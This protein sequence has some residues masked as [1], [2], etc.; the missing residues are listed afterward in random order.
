MVVDERA[1]SAVHRTIGR[2]ARRARRHVR[3]VF[4][5]FFRI[6]RMPIRERSTIRCLAMRSQHH[7]QRIRC[8]WRRVLTVPHWRQ[9]QIFG[10][11]RFGGVAAVTCSITSFSAVTSC[12]THSRCFVTSQPFISAAGDSPPRSRCPRRQ[13]EPVDDLLLWTFTDSSLSEPSLQS[14]VY[15]LRGR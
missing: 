14:S 9:P 2:A 15:R 1:R 3:T 7:A 4:D 11:T 12:P 10:R 13:S 6:D 5:Q 8:A